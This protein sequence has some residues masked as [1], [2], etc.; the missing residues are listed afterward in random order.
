MTSSTHQPAEGVTDFGEMLAHYDV[1]NPEHSRLRW[2]VL[3]YA[4]RECPLPYTDASGGYYIVTRYEDLRYVTQHPQTFSSIAPAT[5][6]NP[7]RLPPLDA[8]PPLHGEF[9]QLLN[10]RLS[11]AALRRHEPLMRELASSTIDQWIDD[12]RCDFMSQFA[13]PF[14]A[15]VLTSVLLDETSADRVQRAVG[16]VTQI[17]VAQSPEAFAGVAGLAAEYLADRAAHGGG[18]A[19]EE[20]DILTALVKGSLQGRPLTDEDRIGV[21]AILF[22]GGL[23]TTRAAI[24]GIAALMAQDTRLEDRLRDPAWVR[25]DL[26][27]MLRYLSPVLTMCRTVTEPVTLGGRDLKPGDRLMLH[28][29]SA[30]RDENQFECPAQLNFDVSRGNA[31][32]GLGIHRCVGSHLARDQIEVAFDELL[33][34][35]RN[36]RLAD[37]HTPVCA[38]GVINTPE[39]LEL[40]FERI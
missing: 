34:R 27:E 19:G 21:I 32:F 25:S 9:R 15:G 20:G 18:D 11:R 10:S 37:G 8:D 12:G 31:A 23:D 1:F 35:V 26:D 28:F 2:E 3:E 4:R 30:N 6:P 7:V 29:G 39:R 13:L 24:G 40:T 22:I 36:L 33:K 38:P 14:T 5:S 17:A 16:Y